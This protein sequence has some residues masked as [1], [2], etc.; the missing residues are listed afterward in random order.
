MT[1]GNKIRELREALKL[2]QRELGECI[3]IDTAFV[4]KIEKG[5]KRIKRDHLKPLSAL[6]KIDEDELQKLWL[7][8]KLYQLVEDEDLGHEALKVAE[9]EFLYNAKTKSNE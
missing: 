3:H 9:A 8:D 1:L 7:A 6:L 5:E 2:S 4:S